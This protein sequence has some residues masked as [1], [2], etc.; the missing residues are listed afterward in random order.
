MDYQN[1]LLG[2]LDQYTRD[3]IFILANKSIYDTVMKQLDQQWFV[4]RNSLNCYSGDYHMDGIHFRLILHKCYHGTGKDFYP[5]YYAIS[6][7]ANDIYKQRNVPV[8]NWRTREP[9]YKLAF[10]K[11]RYNLIGK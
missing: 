11:I 6:G 7:V 9:T 4:L 3:E 5:H 8:R 10:R 2:L 1:T